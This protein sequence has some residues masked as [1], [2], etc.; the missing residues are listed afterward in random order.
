L[1]LA[2]RGDGLGPRLDLT[3]ATANASKDTAVTRRSLSQ[4][5]LAVG[6][7]WG[8]GHVRVTL[9]SQDEARPWQLEASTAWVP[10]RP[11]TL[12]ADAVLHRPRRA[13]AAAGTPLGR[14][15][16]PPRRH[17]RRRLR[18]ALSCARLGHVL[19]QVLAR[20]QERHLRVAWRARHGVVDPG[21]G[22]TGHA[23]QRPVAA[24]RD[25]PRDQ[26]GGTDRGRHDLLDSAQHER[27]AGELYSRTRLPAALSV[28]RRALAI[29]QLTARRR[30]AEAW[31]LCCIDL[32]HSAS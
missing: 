25:L 7:A 23:G 13:R 4:G 21:Y 32:S 24:G 18:A 27:D 6:S 2:R 19:L 12:A 20:V 16:F 3:F 17:R 31:G 26:R 10:V 28:L 9:R 14:L 30:H 11:L 22:G 1:F 29:H 5:I 8:H 15:V